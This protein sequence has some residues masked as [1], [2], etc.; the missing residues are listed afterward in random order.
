V[1]RP[2]KDAAG[3]VGL[4]AAACA[5]CC[6]GPILGFLGG[7]AALGVIGALFIGVAGI[8]IAGS[9]MVATMTVR[10]RRSPTP[11]ASPPSSALIATPT[12][13]REAPSLSD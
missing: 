8:A 11:C 6:A 1:K 7:I 10:G 3:V 9:V 4:G 5:A 2:S 13:R 12:R